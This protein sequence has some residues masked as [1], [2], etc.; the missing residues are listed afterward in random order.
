MKRVVALGMAGWLAAGWACA[1]S[2]R[3]VG[4][5]VN[6]RA[7]ADLKAEVVGQVADGEI[8][9]ARLIGDAWVEVA[10]PDSVDLWVHKDFVQGGKVVATEL[11]VRAG[12]GINYRVVANLPRGAEVKVRGEFTD[13][14][15]IAPP[16]GASLWVSRSYVEPV[17]AATPPPPA[18]AAAATAAG[19]SADAGMSAASSIPPPPP[20]SPSVPAA[21]PPPAGTVASQRVVRVQT[22]REPVVRPPPAGLVL[23]PFEGQGRAVQQDGVLKHAGNLLGRPSR[24]RLV[25]PGGNQLGTLCYVY[26]NNA[27]LETFVGRRLL[28]RGREY[29]V[30]G[31]QYPVVVPDQIIPKAGP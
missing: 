28:I 20:V 6:L 4:Q 2:V 21:P 27:Q 1:D 30:R 10:P 14:L 13:W 23:I 29:W 12:P 8:L 11:K 3:V 22:G 18:E 26:G 15:K 24:F 17:G 19:A 31:V 25:T 7:Q 16:P 9:E 5:R